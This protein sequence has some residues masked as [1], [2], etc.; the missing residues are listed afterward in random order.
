[1]KEH[2]RK[3]K[4]WW[5]A[6]SSGLQ[7]L[8]EDVRDLDVSELFGT[9]DYRR[10][11]DE[12]NLAPVFPRDQK[13]RE[14]CSFETASRSLSIYFGED[15]SERYL[16]AKAWQQGLCDRN[17]GAQ[18]RSWCKVAQKYGVVF[19]RDLPSTYLPWDEYVDIDFHNLDSL[20][21]KNK[22]G[23]Y[24]R[25]SKVK[26]YLRCIDEGYAVALGRLW[27][28]TYN[29]GGG[30]SAPWIITK[31]L[32]TKGYNVGGHATC[33]TGYS[34]LKDKNGV[35]IEKNSY[36]DWWGDKGQFYCEL[37]G[38]QEDLDT[39]GGYVISKV[40]YTPKDIKVNQL[41]TQ[42]KIL[43]N[44]IKG[45]IARETFYNSAL[46]FYRSGE[47]MHPEDKKLG[48]GFA[49]DKVW[50]KAFPDKVNLGGTGP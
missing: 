4:Y 27:K 13:G 35:S 39:Y 40:P 25:I 45:V 37:E 47:I 46:G 1:M 29:Q 41:Q 10:K 2:L 24:Y 19:A 23:S 32:R 16:V 48:C 21:E 42:L 30:F 31:N 28:T 44:M 22:I 5:N 49:M 12:K 11:F 17:G 7:D 15:I 33:G 26:D 14:T 18:L 3:I 36:S 38:L 6:K 43:Q 50:N 9:D 8:I 20:A 34:F